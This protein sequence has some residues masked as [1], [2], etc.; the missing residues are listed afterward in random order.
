[1][2]LLTPGHRTACKEYTLNGDQVI[3]MALQVNE[4]FI[5]Y[6]VKFDEFNFNNL[7][8]TITVE[9]S[10]NLSQNIKN[11]FLKYRRTNKSDS[12]ISIIPFPVDPTAPSTNC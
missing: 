1:M 8:Y 10:I 12:K 5:D 6:Q 11:S 2:L 3:R 7:S 4:L 9:D